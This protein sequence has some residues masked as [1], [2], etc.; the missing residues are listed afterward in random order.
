MTLKFKRI[1]RS[2]SPFDWNARNNSPQPSDYS[3]LQSPPTLW[4]SAQHM[5]LFGPNPLFSPSLIGLVKCIQ[6]NRPILRSFISEHAGL[7]ISSFCLS[8]YSQPDADICSSIRIKPNKGKPGID[9]EGDTICSIFLS[10]QFHGQIY[11]K[12]PRSEKLPL[13]QMTPPCL[14]R[15]KSN[16]IG[17]AHV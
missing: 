11:T 9:L 3:S 8:F 4:L 13:L 14:Q 6:C 5:K 10:I 15:K 1:S 17:R 12:L 16:Q 7:Q 2:S